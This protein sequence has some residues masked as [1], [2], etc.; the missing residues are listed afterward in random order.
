MTAGGS[1]AG[2]AGILLAYKI[3]KKNFISK[4][5]YKSVRIHGGYDESFSSVVG[6]TELSGDLN[7]KNK[8]KGYAL[9]TTLRIKVDDLKKLGL[10]WNGAFIIF[11][12]VVMFLVLPLRLVLK[13]DT[14]ELPSRWLCCSGF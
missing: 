10:A 6:K 2:G 11:I 9:N 5:V 3:A 12:P 1:T 14:T 7:G 8:Q 13:G 4:D